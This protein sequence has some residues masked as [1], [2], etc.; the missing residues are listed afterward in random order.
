MIIF[1]LLLIITILSLSSFCNNFVDKHSTAIKKLKQTN[2]KFDFKKIPE[3]E[4]SHSYDNEISFTNITPQDYLIYQL[5]YKKAD[6]C[7]VIDNVNENAKLYTAYSDEINSITLG[8]Y[9]TEVNECIKKIL[10]SIEKKIFDKEIKRPVIQYL[11]TVYIQQTNINGKFLC[12]KRKA[13][14]QEEILNLIDRMKNKRGDFYLD[15]EIWQA[16]CRVERGRVSNKMRFAIYERDGHRCV[17]CGAR[18][19]PLEIDH[20]FP[21]SK[22]GKSNFD[23][24]Q[25][26]CHNCNVRKSNIVEQGAVNPN[27]KWQG[28]SENCQK[29]GAPLVKRHGKNGSFY[30]CSNYPNC[31]YTKPID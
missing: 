24:L 4:L 16:I 25:T 13:F 14:N 9:D 28:C 2:S 12:R 19:V 29:C 3:Q 20:I 23:N 21:V 6:I 1:L 7:K 27:A 17:K 22:G 5:V 26:L 8:E 18:N 30:G 15:E 31:R 10:N 11:M